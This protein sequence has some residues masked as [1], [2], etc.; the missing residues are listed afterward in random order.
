M[1]KYILGLIPA[2]FQSQRLPGKPLRDIAGKTLIQRTYENARD[3]G[4]FDELVILA[5]DE[6]ILEHA[7][8]F[9]ARCLMTPKQC[10]TGMERLSSAATMYPDLIKGADLIVHVQC[11]EPN[12]KA[13]SIRALIEAHSSSCPITT[14]C[15]EISLEEAKSPSNVKCVF[16]KN[17]KALYF[18]RSL[19][20]MSREGAKIPYHKH[21]GIYA[22]HPNFLSLY[23]TLAQTPCEQ[24]EY[25]EHLKILEHGLDIQLA[26]VNDHPIGVDT[27]QDLKKLEESLCPLNISL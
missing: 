4:I 13:A 24:A 14:L 3:M 17:K 23:A 2:R 8:S 20:P 26:L 16:D 21:I 9:G 18:S 27:E 10:E 6:K 7:K 5:D 22:Y 11:D 19:I 15:T 12:V 1:K 25:L